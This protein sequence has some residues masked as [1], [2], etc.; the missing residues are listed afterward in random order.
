[1]YGVNH[2]IGIGIN[3]GRVVLGD[4]G[5]I[6]RR[7]YTAIGDTVNLTSRIESLTKE[8]G[9]PMLV[10]KETKEKAGNSFVWES[11]E[12]VNVKGKKEPVETFFISGL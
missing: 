3:T 6:E 5:S 12:V 11:A 4:I 9:K 2:S 1:M 7:E 10:S 8:L